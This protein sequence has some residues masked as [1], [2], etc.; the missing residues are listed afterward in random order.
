MAPD[1]IELS[2][3]GGYSTSIFR[4]EHRVR[5]RMAWAPT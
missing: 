5:S 4:A 1:K 2:W 3:S